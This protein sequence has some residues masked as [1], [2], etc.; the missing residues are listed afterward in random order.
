MKVIIELLKTVVENKR[1]ENG[2]M[3]IFQ[4]KKYNIGQE[5]IGCIIPSQIHHSL[6]VSYHNK[7]IF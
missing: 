6:F 4:K 7:L 3:A 2:T 5:I 1:L